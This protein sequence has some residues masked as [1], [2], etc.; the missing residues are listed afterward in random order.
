MRHLGTVQPLL[1]GVVYIAPFG[2]GG[3]PS[4]VEAWYERLESDVADARAIG[5]VLL[6]GD[7]NARVAN[8]S[9][10]C[11]QLAVSLISAWRMMITLL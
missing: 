3:C 5:K 11:H 10:F 8:K 4:D 1:I 7:F 9:V 6:A 2:S